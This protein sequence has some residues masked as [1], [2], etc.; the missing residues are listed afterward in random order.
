MGNLFSGVKS[1]H[2]NYMNASMAGGYIP[3]NKLHIDTNTVVSGPVSS[4]DIK[5]HLKNHLRLA[6]DPS[7]IPNVIADNNTVTKK[8]FID[9]INTIKSQTYTANG[10]SIHT[11]THNIP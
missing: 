1:H 2:Q 4:N 9:G 11:I 8:D 7:T 5:N 6:S 3:Y 10:G